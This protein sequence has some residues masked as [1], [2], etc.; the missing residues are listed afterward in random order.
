MIVRFDT[1]AIQHAIEQQRR[2]SLLLP[3]PAT[4]DNIG[5]IINDPLS[6]KQLGGMSEADRIVE[7][8]RKKVRAG[9]LGATKDD[10]E[11]ATTGETFSAVGDDELGPVVS[12]AELKRAIDGA[13][14]DLAERRNKV[15]IG[16]GAGAGT[17]ANNSD[18]KG[19]EGGKKKG[20]KEG[21]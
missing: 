5:V 8:T 18:N 14:L 10:D 19:G 7:E 6:A 21:E 20:K 16:A 4:T 3:P 1:K 13:N 15:A 11:N 17:N 2:T 12:A 9:T